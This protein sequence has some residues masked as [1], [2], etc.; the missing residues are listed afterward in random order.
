MTNAEAAVGYATQG[1][2]VHPCNDAK[3]PLT[4]WPVA[5]SANPAVVAAYWK[6]W[7]DAL[8][9]LCT[10]DGLVVVDDDRGLAE[11]DPWLAATL[12]SRTRSRGYHH[13]YRSTEDI[14]CSVG[15]VAPGV[16]IRGR[17]GYVIVPPS[18]GWEWIDADTPTAELPAEILTATQQHSGPGNRKPAFEPRDY[19]PHGEV[20]HYLISFSGWLLHHELVDEAELVDAVTEH[21]L[22]VC[23]HPVDTVKVERYARWVLARHRGRS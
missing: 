18:A 15:L 21:A 5:A 11:P 12:T 17:G 9:A 8:I 7:P 3:E 10:G 4:R 2:R 16:D 20:Y 1:R 6:R 19:V 23:Q 13:F 22:Q 14:G